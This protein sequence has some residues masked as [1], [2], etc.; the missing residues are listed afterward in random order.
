MSY[1]PHMNA[2]QN[3]NQA[4]S[5]LGSNAQFIGASGHRMP[6]PA[7]RSRNNGSLSKVRREFARQS[8]TQRLMSLVAIATLP[9][10]LLTAPIVWMQ[11]RDD[12]I[13]AE[14]QMAEQARAIARL[15]DEEFER[16]ELLA[17]VLATSSAR[18]RGDIDAFEQELR[19]ARDT[20]SDNLPP[21][22]QPPIFDL[23]DA[24]G[25]P[26]LSTAWP[27]GARHAVLAGEASPK[28]MIAN[29]ASQI[30]G[31]YVEPATGRAF[32]GIIV[33]ILSPR[34]DVAGRREPVGGIGVAIP[35]DDLVAIAAKAAVGLSPGAA[36]VLQESNGAATAV[37]I[38]DGETTG[39][40]ATATMIA[41]SRKADSGVASVGAQSVGSVPFITAFA[42]A[43]RSGVVVRLDVPEHVLL[44]S[45]RASLLQALLLGGVSLASG[46]LLAVLL[47]HK[48][49]L[50]FQRVPSAIAMREATG[51]GTI[52]PLG[53]READ[54]LAI[55]LALARTAR[56]RAANEART[57]FENSPVGVV[58]SDTGGRVHAA[59]DAFLAM[60]GCSREQLEQGAIRWDDI[61][62]EEWL[63]ED[64]AAI[65]EAAACG[66]C[67]P[68]EKEY[69]RPDGSRVPVLISFTFTDKAAGV[70][71][72]FVID[73]TERRKAAA[74]LRESEAFAT[75]ILDATSDCIAV[76]DAEGR[77]EFMNEPGRRQKEIDD[78]AK[79]VGRPASE[80]WPVAAS[81]IVEGVSE[82]ARTGQPARYTAFEPTAKGTPKFWDITL[83]P[84]VARD[85][86]PVRLLSVAR[87][88]TEAHRKEEAKSHHVEQQ[89]LLLRVAR[90]TLAFGHDEAALAKMVFETVR[91]HLQADVAVNYRFDADSEMLHLV[92][93]FGASDVEASMRSVDLG[94][95]FSGS[96][97]AERLPFIADAGAIADS[98]HGAAV[99]SLGISAY[100]CFPLIGSDGRLLGTLAFGSRRQDGFAQEQVHFLETL[101]DL[102]ALAWQRRHA[103]MA[104]RDSE[105]RFRAIADTMPQI[106]WST[107]ADGYHDYYNQ[108]WYELTGLSRK[109]AQGAGW[110]LVFHP[111]DLD[112]ARDR[113]RH[114]LATGEPYQI[115]YRLRIAD[116][117]YRWMLGRALP[118]RDEVTGAVTRWFGTSTDIEE[119]MA[120]RQALARSREDLEALVAAR[121]RDLEE[122]QARLVQAQRMEALGQLAGGI[123]HDFNNV[124]QA[125]QG[126][127]SLIARRPED[128]ASV[129][130]LVRMMLAATDRGAA[131][132]GRLLAF[133]RRGDLRSEPLQPQM[134]LSGMREMLS[135]TLGDGIDVRIDVAAD[136][137]AILADKSQLETV[138]I[139]LATN[140][141][142]A[143]AGTGTITLSASMFAAASRRNDGT[144]ARR[145]QTSAEQSDLQPGEYV[146]FKVTDTG[147]GMDAATLARASEPFFTTKAA[148][149]GTGLGLAMARGFTEQ[150]G[151]ALAISSMVGVGTTVSLWLPVTSAVVVAPGLDHPKQNATV[152]RDDAQLLLV[153]DDA[154]VREILAEE[155][156]AAGYH[157]RTAASGDEALAMIDAGRP[158]DVVIADLSMPGMNGVAVIREAQRRRQGLCAILLTGFAGHAAEIAVDDA[159]G[160]ISL[161][162]KPIDGRQLGEHAAKLLS[163]TAAE[164]VRLAG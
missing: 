34:P 72:A 138:L 66:R 15:V 148:G 122:T 90:A 142:D 109:P 120:A 39:R 88:V 31:P 119:T 144:A 94:T 4:T 153:D 117:S 127:A 78:L 132:T 29:A 28:P 14:T 164:S 21:N 38:R 30:T 95:G 112:Q 114:S 128:A 115:E 84:L 54:E 83:S 71:A 49:I 103:E 62:P 17:R 59:N 96:V 155:M 40:S 37:A 82:M 60:I 16:A 118:I 106:V 77:L 104:L 8:L 70:A 75:S 98:S 19:A 161:L 3:R 108:R 46:L 157:V 81:T 160:A 76:L 79:V 97:A 143:M 36:A 57:L 53:I 126:G 93:A 91:A 24:D 137:P 116:G 158:V 63:A 130:R 135:H 55:N 42:H 61:T 10:M 152:G 123:A 156:E 141:R 50:A 6:G 92:A 27:R 124:L 100:A 87:D 113:W 73:L 7:A 25:T 18:A 41:A 125:V 146:L 2:S 159:D 110:D 163:Q 56:D 45:L 134:L 47:G 65:A 149:H 147:A 43:P 13:R 69:L 154:A 67:K 101:C 129:Q 5:A 12:R 44:T 35:R 131:I 9:T 32:F 145:G 89:A 105:S 11:Y 52:E 139:N 1:I 74:A 48:I 22:T 20:L 23:L 80:V 121:T 140:A 107:R 58:T 51:A 151:G 85:G 150:S 86:G 162:R 26:A 99:R 64:E 33:P 102:V 136:L 133:S 68:Y 111:D